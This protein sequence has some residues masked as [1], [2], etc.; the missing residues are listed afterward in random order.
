MIQ[1]KN[2]IYKT[3]R[4]KKIIPFQNMG[5]F[6]IRIFPLHHILHKNQIYPDLEK[7]KN[8]ALQYESNKNRY[9]RRVTNKL[10]K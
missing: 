8:T 7:A 2:K 10:P 4:E 6:Y 1:S 3:P 5:N 9:E